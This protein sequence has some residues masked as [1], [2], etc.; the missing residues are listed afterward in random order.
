MPLSFYAHVVNRVADQLLT[1]NNQ[2]K[3][4][5]DDCLELGRA[6]QRILWSKSFDAGSFGFEF[7]VF[8]ILFLRAERSLA[9]IRVLVRL[10]LVDDAMALVRVMV[11]KVITA[12]YILLMGMEPAL[13]FIQFHA[14]SEWRTYQEIKQRSPKL[15]PTF[16][17]QDLKRLKALHDEARARAM[18]DG[19]VKNRYGRGHDWTE[20]SLL[21][22]AEKVDALLQERGVSA[23]TCMTF[24]ASYRKSAAYLHASFIS[25]ARSLETRRSGRESLSESEMTELEVG[26]HLRDSNPRIGVGSL[27]AAATVA[28]QMLTFI[29]GVFKDRRARKWAYA[30]AEKISARASG[31]KQADPNGA[32]NG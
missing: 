5:M 12:E 10:G 19:S 16:T 17:E 32:Q 24:D 27:E 30:F 2:Y 25:I 7:A 28:F 3:A 21:K 9:S 4:E 29:E 15:T 31:Q 23:L 13:D 11:E 1:K 20:L 8:Y 26:I 18:P 6:I 14:F 22:R